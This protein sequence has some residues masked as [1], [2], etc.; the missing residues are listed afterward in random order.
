MCN[1]V[2]EKNLTKQ[3]VQTVLA[4]GPRKNSRN[5]KRRAFNKAI[6]TGKKC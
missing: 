5:N 2:W 6:G 1:I 4:I 3:N